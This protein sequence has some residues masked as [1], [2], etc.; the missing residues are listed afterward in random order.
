[1]FHTYPTALKPVLSFSP[2][3]VSGFGASTD[4]RKEEGRIGGVLQFIGLQ[5]SGGGVDQHDGDGGKKQGA[6]GPAHRVIGTVVNVLLHGEQAEGVIQ[7]V[8]KSAADQLQFLRNVVAV[9]W[10]CH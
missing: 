10:G 5:F 7:P 9:G 3:L 4:R 2:V 6:R 8:V 1:M